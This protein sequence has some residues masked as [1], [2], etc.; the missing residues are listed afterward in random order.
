[1]CRINSQNEKKKKS[2]MAFLIGSLEDILYTTKI[3]QTTAVRDFWKIHSTK[4]CTAAIYV[5]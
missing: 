1:M 2:H 5:S 3:V 4:K